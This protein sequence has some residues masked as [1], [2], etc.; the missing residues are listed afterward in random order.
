MKMLM[1]QVWTLFFRNTK[2]TAKKRTGKIFP[3]FLF[4]TNIIF[5]KFSPS[6]IGGFGKDDS[7]L[8]GHYSMACLRKEEIGDEP[9]IQLLGN[10]TRLEGKV[11]L[12]Q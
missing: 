7:G 3:H 10:E 9:D 1:M 5:P 6:V 12:S 11:W 4:R 2:T 8:R